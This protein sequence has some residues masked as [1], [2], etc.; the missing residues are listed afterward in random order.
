MAGIL[1][2]TLTIL[3]AH[4]STILVPVCFSWFFRHDEQILVGNQK[5]K[6]FL[7]QCMFFVIDFMLGV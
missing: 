2:E 1:P 5:F 3:Y 4:M 6:D 7:A